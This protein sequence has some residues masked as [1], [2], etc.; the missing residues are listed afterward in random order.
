MRL[1]SSTTAVT[2]TVKCRNGLL[3]EFT[4]LDYMLLKICQL[5][6]NSLMITTFIPL[7]LKNS[8]CVSVAL[9]NVEESSVARV[10]V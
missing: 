4:G 2:Q 9:R 1:D 10:N 5:V 7:M 3:M 6:Q 8:N